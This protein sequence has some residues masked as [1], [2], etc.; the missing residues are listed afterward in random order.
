MARTLSRNAALLILDEPTSALDARAESELLERL[1]EL[2]RDR[3]TLLISH[4]FSTVA[5][6]DRIAV[7]HEGTV[8]EVGTHRDLLASNG[9]YARLYELHERHRLERIETRVLG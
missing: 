1:R 2:A 7:M 8:V 9:H 3:T 5:M 6:A 4:R